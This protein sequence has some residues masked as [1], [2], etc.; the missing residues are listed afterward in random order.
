[1][2]VPARPYRDKKT[3]AQPEQGADDGSLMST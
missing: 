3:P 2:T 1:M